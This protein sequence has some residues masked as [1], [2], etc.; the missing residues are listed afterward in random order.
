MSTVTIASEDNLPQTQGYEI[1]AVQSAFRFISESEELPQ[2]YSFALE[3]NSNL[4]LKN[5]QMDSLFPNEDKIE[6][7]QKSMKNYKILRAVQENI[8]E[9]SQKFKTLCS[10]FRSLGCKECLQKL[11]KGIAT[12]YQIGCKVTAC[13]YAC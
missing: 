13:A 12:L 4:L 11:T 8:S 1:S 5:S 6:E 10:I 7:H 2:P 3:L 9:D